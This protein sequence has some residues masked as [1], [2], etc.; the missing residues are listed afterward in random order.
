[1]SDSRDLSDPIQINGKTPDKADQ[2]LYR[3]IKAPVMIKAGLFGIGNISSR[4]FGALGDMGSWLSRS[5]VS[6]KKTPISPETR[7]DSPDLSGSIR[8]LELNLADAFQRL[9]DTKK[10]PVV[11][12]ADTPRIGGL[13]HKIFGALAHRASR[14]NRS[15]L[16]A[17]NTLTLFAREKKIVYDVSVDGRDVFVV[18]DFQLPDPRKVSAEFFL[19]AT[20]MATDVY[21]SL[22]QQAGEAAKKNGARKVHLIMP[23]HAYARQDKDHGERSSISAAITARNLEPYYD[24][25]TSVHLHSPAIKG[26]YRDVTL[27]EIS[28]NEIYTPSFVCRDPVTFEAIDPDQLTLEGVNKLFSQLCIVSPDA[29]GVANAR[30]FAQYCKTFAASMLKVDP[31]LIVDLP[32]ANIDKRRSAANISEVMQVLGREFVEGRRAIIVDDMGDTFGTAT[33]AA[34]ALV[35]VGATGVEFW[36]TH[37]YYAGDALNRIDKSPISEVHITDATALRDE[38]LQDVHTKPISIANI[39][40]QVIIDL[41]TRPESNLQI[42]QRHL[43]AD[44]AQR[45]RLGRYIFTMMPKQKLAA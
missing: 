10:L 20:S 27:N 37:G 3:G 28:P 26:M 32:T 38:V 11:V 6:A 31:D 24:S 42:E 15:E 34:D 45:R 18:L 16:F 1:M 12:K 8:I 35:G 25:V 9:Y 39:L 43:D 33:H 44:E 21:I 30:K 13:S 17:N 14:I 2:G 4:L 19:L 7:S 29:G 22:A 5:V 36:G 41:T 40:A 23:S